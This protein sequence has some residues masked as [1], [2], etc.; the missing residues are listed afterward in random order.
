MSGPNG[1]DG[2]GKIAAEWVAT[3]TDISPPR[4]NPFPVVGVGASAGGLEAFSQLLAALP[5]DTG[6]AFVLVQHLDPIHE[7]LLPELLAKHTAMPVIT[8]ENDLAIEPNRVYVIPPNTSMELQDGTLRLVAR[9]PGL[10][11]PIDIFFKSLA[12]VQGSRAIGIVLSGNASDGSM[13]VRAIKSECGLTFAQDEGT[14]R[15]GAMPRN[16]ASTGAI[17]YILPPAAI[18]RELASIAR[19]PYLIPRNDGDAHSEVLPGGDTELRRIFS[20][21]R[22]GTKVDFTRY[23]PTTIR[24]RIGRRM[25]VTH[26]NSMAEYI[27]EL[28]D[29]PGEL[30]ELYRDLL[31]SVTSF[32]RDPQ[33]FEAVE[34]LVT[35]NLL[36]RRDKEEAFRVWVPGCA[37]GEEVYSLAMTLLGVLQEN[38]LPV[39]LQIFGTDISELALEKARHGLYPS[40][41]EEDVSPERLRR[42]FSK[43]DSGYQ[44]SKTVRECCIFARH[45]VTSD[46]PFSSLDLVSCRNVLIY[47]DQAA[48]RH[49]LPIF[50]YALK[51]SGLLMLGS[52]ESTAAAADLFV[53]VD[54][55][56][57]IY[58]RTASLPRLPLDM[59]R[60]G[61]QGDGMAFQSAPVPSSAMDLQR[62]LERVIQNRYS[63][64]AVLID[65]E[66]Q[67][68][69]FRGHTSLYLDPSPGQATLNVLRMTRESLVVPLRRAVQTAADTNA[70]V[71]ETGVNL[72][73]AGEP[74]RVGLEVTPVTSSEPGERYF[75]VVFVR[76]KLLGSSDGEEPGAAS[77]PVDEQ[78]TALQRELNETRSYLRNM[79]E[80]YEAHS[81]E[82]RA[83]N[84]EARSSNEELQSTNEEL[85][86]TK[87]ELQ[88]TNEELT[89]V[90][91]ETA[92]P[93]PGAERDQQRSQKPVEFGLRAHRDA[94]R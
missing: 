45:D 22:V 3:D 93:Q 84:E 82:L 75:L 19:H 92:K 61:P 52:A 71:R 32:F 16:A 1:R 24:R 11:L 36:A 44:I 73:L 8:V 55:P 54:Q 56:N 57:R 29:N 13:G 86:T 27:R 53:A 88:S 76:E 90:N 28:E 9:G 58:S 15:F 7:S 39:T 30:R 68:V 34:K 91:E 74:Y 78:V 43:M 87:E 83:A 60:V 62:R 85:R 5:D 6:M 40:T 67:I 10:H 25:M 37:T 20:L 12:R 51:P 69:Q 41:I 17:D 64:D 21:L 65:S 2:Q 26:S 59:N 42:F 49:V 38:R 72:E 4:G 23:K 33:S 35:T 66:F 79:T 47:L 50:H 89:T 70:P 18:A 14:A 31:I 63:P 80:Q 81:E 94:G 77:L 46:P 48:Q